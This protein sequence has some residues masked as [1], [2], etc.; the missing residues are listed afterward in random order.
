MALIL[1]GEESV[2]DYYGFHANARSAV[3]VAQSRVAD[4]RDHVRVHTEPRDTE[5]VDVGT[6]TSMLRRG[7]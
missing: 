4:P 2:P 3:Q 6:P 1:V 5:Q 7:E